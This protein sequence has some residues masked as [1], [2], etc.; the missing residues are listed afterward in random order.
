MGKAKY[1]KTSENRR[2]VMDY[3]LQDRVSLLRWGR[4]TVGRVWTKWQGEE[5]LY[6]IKLGN[7]ELVQNVPSSKLTLVESAP[8]HKIEFRAAM[9]WGKP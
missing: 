5:P 8:D 6:D 3:Q 7:G 4:E 9:Q 2:V 1:S